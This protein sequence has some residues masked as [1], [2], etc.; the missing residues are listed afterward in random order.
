MKGLDR[1][2]HFRFLGFGAGVMS[3]ESWFSLGEDD[4]RL[5]GEGGSLVDEVEDNDR[6]VM[7]YVKISYVF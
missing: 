4:V 5:G 6:L 1:D 2:F 7:C 3:E